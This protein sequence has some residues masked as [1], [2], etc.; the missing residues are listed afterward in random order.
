MNDEVDKMLS[1]IKSLA[2][3]LQDLILCEAMT[4]RDYA[5]KAAA[6]LAQLRERVKDLES[7]IIEAMSAFTVGNILEDIEAAELG[8]VRMC[9][10]GAEAINKVEELEHSLPFTSPSETDPDRDEIIG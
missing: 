6:E 1:S 4:D 9:H 7:N 3:P 10:I 5:N 2:T 8:L